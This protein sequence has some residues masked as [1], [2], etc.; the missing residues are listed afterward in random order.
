MITFL[1]SLLLL[2]MSILAA[3]L[4]DRSDKEIGFHEGMFVFLVG[5]G[6]LIY[7]IMVIF[8]SLVLYFGG[9]N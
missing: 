7:V 3:H 9:G 5:F 2:A 6:S 1:L 4:F 8:E